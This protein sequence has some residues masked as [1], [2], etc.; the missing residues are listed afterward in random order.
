MTIDHK[1]FLFIGSNLLLMT[2]CIVSITF[3]PEYPAKKAGL[4]ASLFFGFDL[5]KTN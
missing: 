5:G 3:F 2:T 1:V 4:S